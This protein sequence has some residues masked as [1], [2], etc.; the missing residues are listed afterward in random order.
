MDYE[1]D[2]ETSLQYSECNDS[3]LRSP[4]LKVVL[5]VVLSFIHFP[6]FHADI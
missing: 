4:H 1:E 6:T 3:P 2:I 5:N